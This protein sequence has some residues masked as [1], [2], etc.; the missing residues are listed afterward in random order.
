MRSRVRWYDF[1][2]AEAGGF[3]RRFAGRVATGKDSVSDPAMGI[4]G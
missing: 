2:L 4:A 1:T 3:S